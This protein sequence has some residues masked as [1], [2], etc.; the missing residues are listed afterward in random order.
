[1]IGREIK[2]G[3]TLLRA[4][5][6]GKQRGPASS[7]VAVFFNPAMAFSRDVSVVVLKALVKDHSQSSTRTFR[8]FDGLAGC[9]ARGVR[10]AREVGENL[11]VSINDWSPKAAE[12]IQENIELNSLENATAS[13]MDFSKALLGREGKSFCYIDIDPFGS[14][15][16]YLDIA[17]QAARNGTVLA[18]TA[19][20]TAPLCGTYPGVCLRRYMARNIKRAPFYNESALRILVGYCVRQAAKFDMGLTPLLSHSTDH[21]LRTYLQVKRGVGRAN[22]ALASLVDI[23][24]DASTGKRELVDAHSGNIGP[25][26][27]GHLYDA[28]F[29][30]KL[31]MDPGLEKATAVAKHLSLWQSEASAPALFYDTDEIARLAGISPPP[32][33]SILGALKEGGFTAVKTHFN[34]KGFKTNAEAAEVLEL[35]GE[36]GKA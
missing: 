9:G 33:A 12:L 14:P 30:S 7:K 5:V 34:P 13:N 23:A 8:A 24:Y 25:L 28:E 31:E 26:W 19:T 27:G 35:F 10:L 16:K 36:I 20:D 32:M 1:M 22:L 18:V 29:V 11:E 2:E 15:V 21:Y 3:Q 17:F 4:P 6:G